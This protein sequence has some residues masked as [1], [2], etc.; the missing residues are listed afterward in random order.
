MSEKW[1][2]T[3]VFLTIFFITAIAA[4][5]GMAKIKP[6]HNMADKWIKMLVGPLIIELAVAVI[7]VFVSLYGTSVEKYIF[8]ADYR[9]FLDDWKKSLGERE[10]TCIKSYQTSGDSV[11]QLDESCINI[12]QNLERKKAANN[13]KGL[14]N[15][16]LEKDDSKYSGVAFYTFPGAYSSTVFKVNGSLFDDK[17]QLTFSQER[18]Y[19]IDE[20]GR[21]ALRPPASFQVDF[22]EAVG[23]NGVYEGKLKGPDNVNYGVLRYY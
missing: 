22:K 23:G 7:G 15:L 17:I 18:G 8:V 5:M 2:F 6:F 10:N 4:L 20:M 3:I 21:V 16:Y 14:G 1:V 19:F 9:N 13:Q 12:V 11:A